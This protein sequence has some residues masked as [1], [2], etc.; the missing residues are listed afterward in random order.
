V[1]A[2]AGGI[3]P[4]SAPGGRAAIVGQRELREWGPW[5]QEEEEEEQ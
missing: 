3:T 4:G 2:V 5:K 1:G